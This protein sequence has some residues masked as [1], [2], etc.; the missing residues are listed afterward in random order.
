MES[1]KNVMKWKVE[2]MKKKK[3]KKA[4]ESAI[5]WF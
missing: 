5:S 3:K 1:D 2:K 4:Q